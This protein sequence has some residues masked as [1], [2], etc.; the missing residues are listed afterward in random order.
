MSTSCRTSGCPA[1]RPSR[2]R[3]VRAA[4][5]RVVAATYGNCLLFP[6]AAAKRLSER[7]LGAS[8]AEMA[9]PVAPVNALFA[10]TL[11]L[12][13]RLVSRWPLPAGLSVFVLGRKPV[14]AAEASASSA[15][16]SLAVAS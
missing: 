15:D 6:L 16:P 12:E 7:W 1:M 2:G 8:Q 9:V 4:G 11:A 10:G 5:F 3:A 14:P 13:S